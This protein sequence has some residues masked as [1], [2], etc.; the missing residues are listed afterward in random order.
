MKK[1]KREKKIS[2]ESKLNGKEK[3]SNDQSKEKNLDG[4][5][6]ES[7]SDFDN[8]KMTARGERKYLEDY[9]T[10]GELGGK[11]PPSLLVNIDFEKFASANGFELIDFEGNIN[12]N[13]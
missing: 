11:I 8:I 5:A 3:T 7:D 13:A 9:L 10:L 1:L 12:N 2:K 4:E 6:T